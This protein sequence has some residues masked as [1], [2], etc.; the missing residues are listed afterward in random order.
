MADPATN[1]TTP[2]SPSQMW[3]PEPNQRGTFGII[4]LCLSTLIVCTWNTLHFDIPPRRYSIIRH[5]FLQ[6]AWMIIA[7][8]APE[9]L[10]FLAINE[11]VT[12]GTLLKVAVQYHPDLAEPGMFV[13]MYRYI[14]GLVEW[15]FVSLRCFYSI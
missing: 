7:L 6:L 1:T 2:S 8:Y 3:V 9:L 11:R 14:R 15:I 13:S 12:A 10:L 4:S 5:F